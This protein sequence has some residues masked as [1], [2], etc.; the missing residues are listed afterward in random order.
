MQPVLIYCYD[1]WCGWCYGFSPVMQKINEQYKD[2]W[3]IEV[4]SGGMILPE[5]PVPLKATATYIQGA[6]K[7]IETLTG[8]KFGEDYLWHIFHQ[9]ESDWF[10]HSEKAAIALSIFKEIYPERQIEFI[11]DLQKSLFLEGR[12]LTDNE[13]Y[14][15]LLEKYAIDAAT[16]YGQLSSE[17][18]KEKANFDFT[19]C[20]QLKV[21]GYPQLLL[22]AGETHF[23]L[24]AKGYTGFEMLNQRIASV[25]EEIKVK[26]NA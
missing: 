20:K 18:F 8:I 21:T 11:A 16:F 25:L 5:Q 7:N 10:P 12:D 24:L 19:L 23:Y 22:Q 9:D 3:H 4:L 1:A 2:L 17:E 15:H 6:Y 14:R 13:A 26:G